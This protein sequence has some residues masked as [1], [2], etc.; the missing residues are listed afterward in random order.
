MSENLPTRVG[1]IPASLIAMAESGAMG[2][3][4]ET[5]RHHR[6]L[7]RLNLVQPTSGRD[8][9]TDF[10]EGSV[11]IPVSKTLVIKRG[12]SVDLTPVMFFDEYVTW[13]D[14]D[15]KTGG[16]KIIARSFDRAGEIA[17][18][19]GDAN[20]RKEPY[21]EPQGPKQERFQMS[22]THH[23]NF[24]V[25]LMSGQ[26]KGTLCVMSFSRSA[27]RTGMSFISAIKMR[28]IQVPGRPPIQAPLWSTKWTL[29]VGDRK[30]EKG[31]WYGWDLTAA[32]EPYAADE[33]LPPLRAMHE[34][35]LKEYREQALDVGHEAGE[36]GHD[37]PAAETEM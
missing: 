13:R 10:G 37:D 30:N 6:V 16:A 20:L 35:L 27:F 4:L 34:E 31:E 7:N 17:R 2:D 18:K 22:H 32:T 25:V 36:T 24:P 29:K 15:D 28:K 8:F 14:R 19:A 9:K 26:F 33:E 3:S 12:D 11:I 5:M 23:L 1:N 21:G